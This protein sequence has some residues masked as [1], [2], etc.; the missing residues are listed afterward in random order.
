MALD[1]GN[2]NAQ[3]GTPPNQITF[4]MLI[5][6]GQFNSM[7][8]QIQFLPLLHDQLKEI[9]LEAWDKLPLKENS[10]IATQ[11]YYKGLMKPVLIFQLDGELLS[12]IILSEWKQKYN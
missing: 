11:R 2:I 9:V 3:A 4:K 10:K 8:A 1:H 5:D 12:A 7:E 6:M